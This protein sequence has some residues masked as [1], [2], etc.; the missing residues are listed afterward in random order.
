MNTIKIYN[1][2]AQS[3]SI[4]N[5]APVPELILQEKTITENGTYIADSGYAGLSKVNVEVESYFDYLTVLFDRPIDRKVELTIP[6]GIKELGYYAIGNWFE[7]NKIY[8]LTKVNLNEVEIVGNGSFQGNQSL[9]EVN[10]PNL[11][12]LAYDLFYNC[13]SLIKL[14]FPNV[15]S[16]IDS[17]AFRQCE[18]LKVVKFDKIETLEGKN[19][20]RCYALDT[21]IIATPK[22]CILKTSI[23][24]YATCFEDGTASIYVQDDLVEQYKVATNW[25]QYASMIKPLSEY[26]G[27]AND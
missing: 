18:N 9:V 8:G 27:V 7:K 24:N 3:I 1:T 2:P 4:K 16:A 5:D 26:T 25:V 17:N 22:V 20:Q 14:H 21:L 11:T 12:M 10:A 15:I 6:N 23:G 19:F 13:L